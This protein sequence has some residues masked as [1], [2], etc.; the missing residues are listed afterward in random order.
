MCRCSSVTRHENACGSDRALYR[1]GADSTF[2]PCTYGGGNGCCCEGAG[3]GRVA[4]AG[5]AAVGKSGDGADAADAAA[6]DAAA[7]DAAA[8]AAVGANG[9]VSDA[10][11]PFAS[12][13]VAAAAVPASPSS[14]ADAAFP[15]AVS[16]EATVV[17]FGASFAVSFAAASRFTSSSAHATVFSS[18]PMLFWLTRRANSGSVASVRCVSSLILAYAGDAPRRSSAA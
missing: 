7:E 10:V 12:T 15:P 8:A 11:V 9:C 14:A 16:A 2:M 5:W 13:D 3:G 18:L 6:E 4:G 1:N 17:S